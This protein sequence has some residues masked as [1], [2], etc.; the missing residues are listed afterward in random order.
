MTARHT[1][2]QVQAFRHPLDT[3]EKLGR[4]ITNR[5]DSVEDAN[6]SPLFVELAQANQVGVEL[7]DLEHHRQSSMLMIP[8]HN[9]DLTMSLDA[10]DRAVAEAHWTPNRQIK[11]GEDVADARHMIGRTSIK[12]PD[13]DV[14][15]FLLW[16]C[17]NTFGSMSSIAL[18]GGG[19]GGGFERGD[20]AGTASMT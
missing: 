2:Y 15:V 3:R 9:N 14:D 1:G 5:A 8:A 10:Y 17:T 13:T 16:R 20:C 18:L 7:R 4:R 6:V 19:K 11:L 12:V